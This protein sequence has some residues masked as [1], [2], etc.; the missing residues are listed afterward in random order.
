MRL[1]P[2]LAAAAL[3]LVTSGAHAADAGGRG[4]GPGTV[5]V[6]GAGGQ[7]AVLEVTE[8]RLTL[9]YRLDGPR[10]P[11]PDG[12][13]GGV[14]VQRL[15]DRALH[16]VVLLT[17]VPGFSG[18]AGL[19]LVGGTHTQLPRG[20]YALTLL[21]DGPQRVVFDTAGRDGTTTLTATGPARSITR[22]AFGSSAVVHDFSQEF[23]I[24]SGSTL[25][26][27]SMGSA[28]ALQQASTQMWCLTRA[29]RRQDVCL[30]PRESRRSTSVAST[31]GAVWEAVSL[32]GPLRRGAYVFAGRATS[33]GAGTASHSVVVV[34]LPVRTEP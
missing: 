2:L 14:L 9:D 5:V 12:T 6:T 31:D 21:G 25:L 18:T 1:T 10:L 27:M 34:D 24:T 3:L 28:G 19:G 26:A 16:G 22:T 8:P 30:Q 13:V 7:A 32:E 17:N 29:E 33:V 20:R 15:P 4:D 11:G 23:L